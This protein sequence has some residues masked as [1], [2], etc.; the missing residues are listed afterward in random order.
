MM[1]KVSSETV[2]PAKKIGDDLNYTLDYTN[3]SEYAHRLVQ[4]GE[5]YYQYVL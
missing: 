1:Q 2:S 5:R 4:A 3:D